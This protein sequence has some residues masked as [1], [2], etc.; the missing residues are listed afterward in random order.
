MKRDELLDLIVN[1]AKARHENKFIQNS[2]YVAIAMPCQLVYHLTEPFCMC[3]PKAVIGLI[4]QMVGLC[5][6]LSDMAGFLLW[7]IQV[8]ISML[9]LVLTFVLSSP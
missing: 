6:R 1:E 3:S 7:R 2:R 9:D 4:V 5:V 8:L